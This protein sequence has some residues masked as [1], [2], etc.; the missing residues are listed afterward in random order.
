M[1]D[2]ARDGEPAREAESRSAATAAIAQL[3]AMVAGADGLGSPLS[4]SRSWTGTDRAGALRLL[5]RLA[6]ILAGARAVLL[7]AEQDAETSLVPGDRDF[8]SARARVTRTGL[9]EARREVRQAETLV[10]LPAMADAVASG[11]VPLPHVDALARLT[12]TA[13]EQASASLRRPEVADRLVG[14]AQRLPVKEFSASAARLLA[15]ADPAA[16][17]RSIE[18]QRRARFFVMSHQPE[19]TFLRGRLDRLSAQALQTALASVRQAPDETRDKPQAD[20]DALVAL[21]ERAM[22]G[23]AGVRALRAP[24]SGGVL[25]DAEQDEVDARVTGVAN[26]PTVSVLVPATT[27][28]ELREA[29]RRRSGAGEA[30]APPRLVEP[31]T[32]DD[33]TPLAMSQLARLLCDCEIGRIVLSAES[34]PLDVG[35]TR[36]VF[37]AAQRRAVI[38]RDRSCSWN[39]CDVPAAFCEI[40]HIRWWDR[41]AGPTDLDNAV[42]LCSHHHHVVHQ[43]D[44]LITRVRRAPLADAALS[45]DVETEDAAPPSDIGTQGAARRRDGARPRDGDR[46]GAGPRDGARPRDGALLPEHWE[47]PMITEP[48][49][50]RFDRRSGGSVNA[51][52]DIGVEAA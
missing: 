9:G 7:V 50:Y 33:G 14:L 19:G 51:P 8:A 17:E 21:A 47:R 45:S 25:Q 2:S 37:T 6:G 23:M 28:V 18:A 41:D 10:A 26:R 40:H 36:R 4:T 12:A 44:L 32:F 49:E 1:F 5:D 29:E 11:R 42:L 22:S 38:V 3:E 15:A 39:G 16:L 46:D 20:A 35:R 52:A 13:G 24:G 43:Q 27:F 31:A 48:M 30:T 34:V